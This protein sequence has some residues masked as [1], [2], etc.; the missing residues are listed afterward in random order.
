MKKIIIPGILAGILISIVLFIGQGFILNPL[1]PSLVEEYSNTALYRPWSVPVMW[2]IFLYPFVQ[3]IALAWAWDKTK[4]I[5]K[6]SN[7]TKAI[8]FAFAFWIVAIVPSMLMVY[9]CIPIS[10]TVI[11][12]WTITGF[13]Y[14][15]VAGLIFTRLNP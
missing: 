8:H 12:I 15:L 9:S 1:F 11:S 13:V 3:G 4:N 5:F 2:L 10:F 6:G 14:G 7:N